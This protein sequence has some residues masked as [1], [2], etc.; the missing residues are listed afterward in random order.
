MILVDIRS[1]KIMRISAART[2]S[3]LPSE[4]A[5]LPLRSRGE[6]VWSGGAAKVSGGAA[7]LR[8]WFGILPWR[9]FSNIRLGNVQACFNS[10]VLR[11]TYSPPTS[12][13]KSWNAPKARG[14]TLFT[15]SVNAP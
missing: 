7:N 2:I 13:G 6:D 10:L 9:N 5:S 12:E 8:A 14:Y 3:S 11:I 15:L 4:E 1:Q